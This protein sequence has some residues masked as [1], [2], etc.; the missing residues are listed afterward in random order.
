CR[1]SNKALIKIADTYSNLEY[2]NIRNNDLL[3]DASVCRVSD[4]CHNLKYFRIYSYQLLDK[5]I[6]TIPQSY[7]N[8]EEFHFHGS[9]SI[10]NQTI[11]ELGKSCPKLRYLT[12]S[13]CPNIIDF[14]AIAHSCQNL[15]YLDVFRCSISDESICD[16][17]YHY[18]K[19]KYLDISGC[20]ITKL[21]IYSD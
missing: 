17:I 10:T 21:G 7:H 4:K 16:I 3:T 15:E 14:K 9:K 20:Q 1:F 18:Q 8:L 11:N 13:G 2:L 19:L 12:I 6:S 5:S